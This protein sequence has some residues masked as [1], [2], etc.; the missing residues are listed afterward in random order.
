[1]RLCLPSQDLIDDTVRAIKNYDPSLQVGS[2]GVA[3]A[4]TGTATTSHPHPD[5]YIHW[6]NTDIVCSK[7]A[8]PCNLGTAM[9]VASLTA[10]E[11][12]GG[13]RTSPSCHQKVVS[14][15]NCT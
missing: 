3:N 11:G 5:G 7:I 6:P 4:R 8:G 2:D 12:L 14:R 9:M 1:M 10:C 13:Q 15:V